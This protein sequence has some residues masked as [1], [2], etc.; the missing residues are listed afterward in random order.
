MTRVPSAEGSLS[1]PKI[2][3]APTASGHHEFGPYVG[4]KD[5][6]VVHSVVD[7]LGLN[8][9]SR[10]VL[11][12]AARAMAGLVTHPGPAPQADDKPLVAATMSV[13]CQERFDRG[14]GPTAALPISIYEYTA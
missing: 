7:I 8:R 4:T 6:M 12:Q 3:V 10:Q 5:V 2:V 9:V 11:S 13:L 14:P 1:V